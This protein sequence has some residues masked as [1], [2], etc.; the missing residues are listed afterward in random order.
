MIIFSTQ[1]IFDILNSIDPSPFFVLSIIPYIA[2]LFWAQKSPQIPQI[3]LWGFRLTLL[4][5]AVTIAFAIIAKVLF[6]DELTNI[7]PL[8][9]SAEAFLALSD[10]LIAI[11]FFGL[12][13]E[14]R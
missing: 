10:A 11:G 12:L 13:Q 5:V 1:A 8:H 7:D 2:F 14:K 4:F 9:G 3:S 6:G